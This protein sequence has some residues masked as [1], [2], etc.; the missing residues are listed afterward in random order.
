VA[1][2]DSLCNR[3]VCESRVFT[4]NWT[5]STF[6]NLSRLLVI[7][8]TTTNT[9]YKLQGSICFCSPTSASLLFG[10]LENCYQIAFPCYQNKTCLWRKEDSNKYVN[11]RR[12]L[13]RVLLAHC[14]YTP[15]IVPVKSNKS[16]SWS[17]N[18]LLSKFTNILGLKIYVNVYFSTLQQVARLCSVEIYAVTL[19]VHDQS[20][21]MWEKEVMAR[22]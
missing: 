7:S 16:I 19:N 21:C 4:G 14:R 6:S 5:W 12:N 3:P 13:S 2:I 1:V 22:S 15:E 9:K 11:K 10:D 8:L 20:S 17:P 18:L